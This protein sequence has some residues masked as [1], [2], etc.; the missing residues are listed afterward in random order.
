LK[1]LVSADV[2]LLLN[3]IQQVEHEFGGNLMRVQI[4]FAN[5]W[6]AAIYNSQH[7]GS[8]LNSDSSI[9]EDVFLHLIH[10]FTCFASW[11]LS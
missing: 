2:T 6:N 3:L 9:F 11:W 7:V 5:T 10:I 8:F 1:V 4:V